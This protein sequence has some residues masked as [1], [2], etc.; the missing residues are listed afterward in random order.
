MS[1]E[2]HIDPKDAASAEF[3]TKVHRV[4]IREMIKAAKQKR[5]SQS[6][7][8][9]LLDVDKAVVSRALNGKSNLT[10]RTISDLCWAIGVKPKFEACEDTPP[11]GSN[12]REHHHSAPPKAPVTSDSRLGISQ[13]NWGVEKPGVRSGGT[14]NAK[15]SLT[16]F[17]Y[18]R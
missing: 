17:E 10:I 2:F 11:E 8:A 9:R 14:S 1:F 4:L 7:V 18:V 6:D 5:I 12:G 16:K 3:M 13:L 15:K